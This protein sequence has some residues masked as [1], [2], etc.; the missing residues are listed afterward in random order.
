MHLRVTSSFF[1]D[2]TLDMLLKKIHLNIDNN[3][4]Y[5]KCSGILKIET[6]HRDEVED[7]IYEN[8]KHL[9]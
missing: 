7:R 3:K 5:K 6:L 2:N 9:L 1:A 8:M 4:M